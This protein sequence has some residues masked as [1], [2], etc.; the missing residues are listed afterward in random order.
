MT[1]L[2][3]GK[4]FPTYKDKFEKRWESFYLPLKRRSRLITIPFAIIEYDKKYYIYF[5]LLKSIQ[6]SKG[7]HKTDGI[8]K[9]IFEEVLRFIPVLEK[10]NNNILNKI[11][12]FDFRAGKIKGK[13]ILRDI[14]PKRKKEKI[15]RCY[16]RYLKNNSKQ[17]NISL[18]DY[19][20]VAKICYKAAFPKDV[21]K[22]SPIEMHRKWSDTRDGGML[23]I[24]N[25]NSKKE[26]KAWYEKRGWTGAHPFEIVYSWRRHGIHLYPPTD[27]SSSYSL[28][29]TNYA[30]ANDFIKMVISLM[31]EKIPFIAEDIEKV[32]D[33]LTGESYFDVNGYSDHSFSYI[34]SR[35]YKKEYFPYIEW[36]D[37]TYLKW[38]G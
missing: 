13:Y 30:Y 4:A 32:L 17:L 31:N 36:D 38:K 9:E 34:P 22:M 18:N 6:I 5:Y 21:K 25:W 10:T 14:L 29:V 24:M 37:L 35:E 28:R 20:S 7:S 16:Q 12:P 15:L 1:K 8:Y 2:L 11:T 26:F 23:S 27:E 3:T 33:F 19:I